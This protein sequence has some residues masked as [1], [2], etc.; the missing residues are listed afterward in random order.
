[1]KYIFKKALSALITLCLVF[2]LLPAAVFAAAGESTHVTDED[3]L[4]NAISAA[5]T[6]DTISIDDNITLVSNLNIDKNVVLTATSGYS[7]NAGINTIV[8]QSG[9][10]VTFNGNLRVRGNGTSSLVEVAGVFTLTEEASVGQTGNGFAILNSGTL[11]IEQNANVEG[12]FVAISNTVEGELTVTD[13]TI[14]ALGTSAQAAIRNYGTLTVEGGN[15]GN[16]TDDDYG[17]HHPAGGTASI[18]G[19]TIC[20]KSIAILVNA[21]G[22]LDISG[23]TFTSGEDT[24][25]VLHC[26]GTATLTGGTFTSGRI[27]TN[28]SGTV[29]IYLPGSSGITLP[30]AGV[31]Y[32]DAGWPKSF[33]TAL[34]TIPTNVTVEQQS[35]V[36]LTGANP[37]VAYAVVGSDTSTELG[38]SMSGDTTVNMT[39]TAA[40][41]YNLVLTAAGTGAAAGQS[42]KLT[43]PVTVI[44]APA[45]VCKIGTKEYAS[46][47]AAIDDVPAGGAQHT[48]I[49]LQNI[50]HTSPV[51]IDRKKIYFDLNGF[52]L[53]I[54]ARATNYSTALKAINVSDVIFNNDGKMNISGSRYGVYAYGYS[55]I[56][57]AGDVAATGG[58]HPDSGAYP[59]TGVYV[60]DNSTVTIDGSVTGD[61]LAEV[62][63]MP[64]GPEDGINDP[65]K[66][67]YIKYTNNS[68]SAVWVKTSSASV[69][70]AGSRLTASGTTDT[71]TVLTWTA[72]TGARQYYVIKGN[73]NLGTMSADTLTCAVTGLLPDTEYTFQVQ[74][75][76]LDVATNTGKWT[77]DGPSVTVR[78]ARTPPVNL[79][80][81]W[82]P[83]EGDIAGNISQVTAGADG[84]LAAINGSGKLIVSADGGQHWSVKPTGDFVPKALAYAG[85]GF[86]AAGNGIMTSSDGVNWTN[87][88][89]TG[90][91]DWSGRTINVLTAANTT[92]GWVVVA[93]GNNGLILI[94]VPNG[95]GI[96]S[97]WFKIY[98]GGGN[99]VAFGPFS[100]VPE[101]SAGGKNITERFVGFGSGSI[102]HVSSSMNAPPPYFMSI[103]PD[104]DPITISRF[105]K[106]WYENI[107]GAI[108]PGK[109]FATMPVGHTTV[110]LYASDDGVTWTKI[111]SYNTDALN[112]YASNDTGISV[113]VGNSGTIL[114]SVGGGSW[115][116]QNPGIAYDIND[117]IFADGMFVAVGNHGTILTSADG[118]T[119]HSCTAGTTKDLF[120]INYADG[121]FLVGGSGVILR[122]GD[123]APATC[124]VTVQ[125]GTGSGSYTPGA[126][127]IITANTP[128]S[129][130]RFKEWSITPSVTFVE[131]TDATSST[132]KFTMPAQPVLATAVYGALP[133][134]NYFI[135]VQTGGNGTASANINSAAQGTEITLTATPQSG[136]QFKEW[137]V[138]SGGMSIANNKFIMPAANVT[139]RAIFEPILTAT[140]AVTVSGSYA[141]T[142]GSGSYAQ[143][144]SVTIHAGSR[145]NYSFT[146][147]TSPDEVT[148]ANAGS[149]TTTFTMPAKSVSVTANWSY[150]GGGSGS[151]SDSGGG[152]ST[153]STPAYKANV[154]AGDTAETTIPVV[155][156]KDAGTASVEAGSKSL[157]QGG[158]VI[159]MPSIPNVGA[160]SVGIPIPDLSTTVVQGTLTLNTDTG[161]V[162]VPSNMLTGVA[163]ISGS[164]AQIT[165]SQGNRNNLPAD[166][167]AAIGDRPLVQLTLAI[168]GKQAG[169]SNPAAH[170][171]VSI[172]YAPTAAELAS[173][174]SIV[175]WY[176]DGSGNA[177]LIPNGHY[178]KTTGTVTFTTTHFSN[179]AVGYSRVIFADVSSSD[180][181]SKAVD[182]IAARKITTGT[183]NGN[184]GPNAKLTRGEFIVMLLRTFDIA[185]DTNRPDNF[186]DAGNTYYTGYLAAA[187]KLGI[188]GGVGNNMFAPGKQ[189]TR[190][191]MF[192]LLYNVLKVIGQLP[193]GD[194]GKT[195]DQ[196]TDAGQIDSWAKE[197]VTLLVKTGTISGFSGKLTPAGTTT[198]AE[199]AQVLYNLLGK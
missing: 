153:P 29:N 88:T 113:K 94:A 102:Y 76:Y 50:T 9:N 185:P 152:P 111:D 87:A 97:D 7:L 140:Y 169:W 161:S 39:P 79:D 64:K 107:V 38:A 171:A 72:A 121:A 150:N 26:K 118:E 36:S 11:T 130:Q 60:S 22:T 68:N 155:A 89:V 48:I 103:S 129:G 31:F 19:G 45:N 100:Y 5:E 54:D 3:G 176:I 14:Q 30:A 134:N 127:V 49:L 106:V 112:S 157:T 62:N 158:I 183:G 179:Y 56:A 4:R 180:W 162:T 69:W 17:I 28:G 165:I 63:G 184:Y 58:I 160:Y 195:L 172:P 51:V 71:G 191:E 21:T 142:T 108:P 47:D 73:T 80:L 170:V 95:S 166:V 159:K 146:G 163:G 33:L 40:G 173:P 192:T 189:I 74:A 105:T 83:A 148:F 122:S 187:K 182:F 133:A 67:G 70:P 78:T 24:A 137:Q 84:R 143:D 136:Y 25:E 66:P 198:R 15:I 197:A 115:N 43:I 181:F 96:F 90:I 46:L 35:A 32:N 91:T 164:K 128:A 81:S 42:I 132:A 93:G 120:D 104:S 190:Q 138:V 92:K 149:A 154:K 85:S 55:H 124:L 61:P 186:T 34:P 65:N 16:T 75:A 109:F 59:G 1:M 12:I 114:T 196:F 145:S 194:S 117:V 86:I 135:T 41:T 178:D 116:K 37:G 98:G 2:T 77:T 126:T 144:D 6:G 119:W 177:V 8:I 82:S 123:E 167:K 193:Q 20:G 18:S 175:I 151:G 23:G 44:A 10:E 131:G 125:G 57:L 188:S 199:M 27:A 147:W 168:D 141:G 174:E 156:N 139:V 110:D 53:T 99:E 101:H 13:G 52:D